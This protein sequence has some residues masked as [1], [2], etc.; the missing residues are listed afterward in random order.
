M[1]LELRHKSLHVRQDTLERSLHVQSKLARWTNDVHDALHYDHTDDEDQP[2]P[3]AEGQSGG[4][5]TPPLY[6]SLLLVLQHESTIALNRPLLAKTP[7]TSASQAALEACIGASRG[8]LETVGNQQLNHT[9][10]AFSAALMVWPLLTWSVWMSCFILSYA[11]LEGVTSISSALRFVEL[12]IPGLFGKTSPA[13]QLQWYR[14][15]RRT[16]RTLGQL[17]KRGTS[18]PDSCAQA[19]GH[20]IAALEQRKS[21]PDATSVSGEEPS[22]IGSSP[23]IGRSTRSHNRA[24]DK[25]FSNTTRGGQQE[26]ETQSTPGI[27]TTGKRQRVGATY[28]PNRLGHGPRPAETARP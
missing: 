6:H 12:K 14:Y 3:A 22:A 11:A 20:L 1:I 15:A 10:R 26:E 13:D 16:L 28:Q 21:K 27:Q 18:W 25:T 2:G 4:E 17:S 23:S 7:R 9:G 5:R 8:I 19:V 24:S